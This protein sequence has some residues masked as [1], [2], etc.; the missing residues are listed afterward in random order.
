MKK[1]VL[2]FVFLA[3]PAWA[4][5]IAQSGNDSV[6]LRNEPCTLASV[7]AVI[8]KEL[9]ESFGAAEAKI[10]G[11]TYAA[12]WTLRSDGMVYFRYADLDEGLIPAASFRNAPE[13]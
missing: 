4:D 1:L 11:A 7:L 5:L 13:V 12:C 6:R 9:H 3:A 8:P 10:G 2:A